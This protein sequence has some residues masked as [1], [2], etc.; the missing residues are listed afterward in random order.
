MKHIKLFEAFESAKINKTLSF[1]NKEGK[2]KFLDLIKKIC[3]RYDLPESRL[4][5][6]LFEY[7][8]YNKAI[9]HNGNISELI[10][11]PASCEDGKIT[12]KYGK[13]TRKVTCNTCKGTG[14][15]EPKGE[16]SLIKFWFSQNGEYLAMTGVDGTYRA[17]NVSDNGSVAKTFSKELS[18]YDV[19]DER[20]PKSRMNEILN[21]GDIVKLT[22]IDRRWSGNNDIENVVAFIVRHNG[23]LWAIQ[24]RY[25][26]RYDYINSENYRMYGTHAWQMTAGSIRSIV[27]LKPKETVANINDPMGYN[28]QLDT[29]FRI[30]PIGIT[31]E[32]AN[33]HFSIVLDL[34]KLK[35]ID[36]KKTDILS[37]RVENKKGATALLSDAD[38][39][40][41]NIDRYF[42]EIRKRSKIVGSMEDITNFNKIVTRLSGGNKYA[43]YNLLYAGGF[44]VN[45]PTNIA[46]NILSILKTINKKKD[47][48]L[49]EYLKSSDF[50]SSI[51]YTN[52]YYKSGMNSMLSYNKL[53]ER[54]IKAIDDS[55]KEDYTEQ[56]YNRYLELKELMN[57]L[58][59]AI[60]TYLKSFKRCECLEDVTILVQ[61]ISSLKDVIYN[62]IPRDLNPGNWSSKST[63][64]NTCNYDERFNT[65]TDSLNYLISVVNR[66]IQLNNK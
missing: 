33:A 64:G 6:N 47:T 63:Y 65:I 22:I 25:D 34:N 38:I 4:N 44:M 66:K 56:I 42:A 51:D 3:E 60:N 12:R 21:T 43:L 14:K 37:N 36:S 41:A 18:D 39:K 46:S 5:D 20:V 8:P 27:K 30:K 48:E 31:S 28:T 29:N 9:K 50:K 59:I 45:I 26:Y 57:K 15:V 10:D 19:V 61:D 55:I 16:L 52:D 35:G 53:H 17:I 32:I 23:K 13:G 11:C 62:N 24:D 2:S 40:L 58:S 1:L 54:N 49:D 7:L